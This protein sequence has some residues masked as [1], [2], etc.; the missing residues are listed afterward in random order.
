MPSMGKA[1]MPSWAGGVGWPSD[2][3]PPFFPKTVYEK[4][5]GS[6]SMVSPVFCEGTGCSGPYPPSP[7]GATRWAYPS[8]MARARRA[9]RPCSAVPPTVSAPT[10]MAVFR[11]KERRFS[12]DT[13]VDLL[14]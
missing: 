3:S 11:M 12:R 2:M 7:R 1:A 9:I 13:F 4:S 10:D 8:A 6:S 14:Y 5:G